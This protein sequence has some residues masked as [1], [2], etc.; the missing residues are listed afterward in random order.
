MC[1]FFISPH[2]AQPFWRPIVTYFSRNQN[3]GKFA[4]HRAKNLLRFRC[5]FPIWKI[6]PKFNFM[7]GSGFTTRRSKFWKIKMEAVT[8]TCTVIGCPILLW[9]L[10]GVALN[11]NFRIFP[12]I[13]SSVKSIISCCSYP[14][15][16]LTWRFLYFRMLCE[17]FTE[18]FFFF[19]YFASQKG[20]KLEQKRGVFCYHAHKKIYEKSVFF[21]FK[22]L[23][24]S[25]FFVVVSMTFSSW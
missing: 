21:F 15:I 19:Y 16:R 20:M 25:R 10:H 23:A 8:Y 18:C 5:D 11:K 2:H 24:S 1:N 14:G 12:G 9:I 13:T 3:V 22:W 7:P 6:C 4:I 17:F